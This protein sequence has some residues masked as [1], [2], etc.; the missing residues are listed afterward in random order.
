MSVPINE[1]IFQV[2]TFGQ[3][4]FSK[5]CQ[6][7]DTETFQTTGFQRV[8]FPERFPEQSS[9]RVIVTPNSLGVSTGTHNA[10]LV[11]AVQDVTAEGFVLKARNSDCADEVSLGGMN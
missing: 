2:G 11:G 1:A 8:V 5:D 10:A 6:T 7:G 3:R 9:V 4:N